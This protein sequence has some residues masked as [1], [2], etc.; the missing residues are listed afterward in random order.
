MKT[1]SWTWNKGSELIPAVI[2]NFETKDVL[3]LGYMN[4]ESFNKTLETGLITFFSR[5]K[6]RL[7]TKGE[8][9]K[10]YLKLKD[11][12]IDCDQ[13]TFLFQ[14]QP[15]GPTC[16]TGATTCFDGSTEDSKSMNAKEFINQNTDV[17]DKNSLAFLNQLESI[18][19]NRFNSKDSQKSYVSK[20]VEEGQDRIIQKV[21]E[22]AIEVV[23]AAKNSDDVDFKNETADLLFHL[24]VLLK[25]KGSSLGEIIEILKARHK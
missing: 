14:A 10:N 19:T 15:E 13:D 17:K 20:L 24:M 1:N 9:S 6:N 4:E 11:W 8:S 12:S 3:M 25:S 16:H 22:E 18:I 2:Q 7:W 21:G 23:I 5:S